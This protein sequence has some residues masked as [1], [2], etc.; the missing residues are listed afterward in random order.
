MTVP[1]KQN[2]F[3]RRV[4]YSQSSRP[5][6]EGPAAE[7]TSIAFTLIE[8]LVVMAIISLLA[9]LLMPA[10]GRAKESGRSAACISNLR[11][12]GIA[13]QVYVDGNYHRLPA[14][15]NKAAGTNQPTNS[16]PSPDVALRTELG[17]TNVMRCPS[18]TKQ[19]FD[20]TGSSYFWNNLLNGQNANQLRV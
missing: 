14:M 13:L 8:L 10:V 19:I 3:C 5:V 17:N 9:A 4:S 1:L 16:L 7:S 2:H 15:E 18:D 20:Q 11:Q 6:A 12:I